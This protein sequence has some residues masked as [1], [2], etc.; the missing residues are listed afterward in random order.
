[1]IY[2]SLGIL[3]AFRT[4]LRRGI[5]HHEIR[6]IQSFCRKHFSLECS[7]F[8][9]KHICIPALRLHQYV[10]VSSDIHFG[11]GFNFQMHSKTRA[12]YETALL[13]TPITSRSSPGLLIT[14]NCRSTGKTQW[15]SVLPGKQTVS[16]PFVQELL[17]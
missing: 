15:L 3:D 1:M 14:F 9:S 6:S 16:R 17:V 8:L 7:T 10:S 4:P 11:D 12:I 13:T 2:L 5:L